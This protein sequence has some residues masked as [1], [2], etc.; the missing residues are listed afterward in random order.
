[1]S[2]PKSFHSSMRH[3]CMFEFY[4]YQC[5]GHQGRVERR[6][7]LYYRL[8]RRRGAVGDAQH[9]LELVEPRLEETTHRKAHDEG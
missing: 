4:E 1:M 2:L 7:G 9:D 5:D 3:Y 6:S 8:G